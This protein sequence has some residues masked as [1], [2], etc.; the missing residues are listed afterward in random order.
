M[1]PGPRGSLLPHRSP[2]FNPR[3]GGRCKRW[4]RARRTTVLSETRPAAGLTLL[5]VLRGGLELGEDLGVTA[6]RAN[7]LLEPAPRTL[8]PDPEGRGE[9][10]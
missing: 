7:D 2:R 10:T 9:G 8:V 5:R 1:L 6:G 3:S 4:V